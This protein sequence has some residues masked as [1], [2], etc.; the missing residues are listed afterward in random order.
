MN[1]AK[2]TQKNYG[3]I[4]ISAA[5]LALI[6]PTPG[7]YL[8][9]YLSFILIVIMTLSCLRIDL[10]EFRKLHLDWWRYLLILIYIFVFPTLFSLLFK[11]LI[12]DPYI[13]VGLIIVSATPC[14]VSVISQSD[15]M[16]GETT[17][18][19]IVTTL[20]H[21]IAPILTPFLVWLAVRQNIEVNFWQML[22]TIA[23]LV[24]L[25]LIFAQILRTTRFSEKLS[26]AS[27]TV[28]SWLLT[29][30]ALGIISPA[31]MYIGQH[32]KI[33]LLI[34]GIISVTSTISVLIGFWF[35][36]NKKEAITWSV[37]NT[38][39]NTTLSS[40]IALNMFG[41]AAVIG[42][43]A[44][45]FITTFFIGAIQLTTRLSRKN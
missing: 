32:F 43:V 45:L 27:S 22:L 40:L 12:S 42:S 4:L 21:I 19:L 2:F 7:L 33:F 24:I 28:N 13:F 38:Y 35:G 31:K 25:P 23:R 36:R 6:Y 15:I 30:I 20:A 3:L 29:L 17:K 41:P 11:G 14:A 34:V 16:G 10:R 8:K 44:H 5:I 9:P 39:K 18:A 1:F 37:V 26:S